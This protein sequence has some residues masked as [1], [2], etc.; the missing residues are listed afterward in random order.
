MSYAGAA[1]QG[2]YL[3]LRFITKGYGKVCNRR[4]Q[5]ACLSTPVDSA[6]LVNAGPSALE[7]NSFHTW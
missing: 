3:L 7:G 1:R 6:G 4:F 5:R 2:E